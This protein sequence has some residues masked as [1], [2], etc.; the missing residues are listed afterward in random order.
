ML[1]KSRIDTLG[2]SVLLFNSALF[3][4]NQVLIKLV[5]AGLQPVLQAGLRSLLGIVPLLVF[6]WLARRRL[7]ISDGSLLPGLLCG[8]LFSAEFLFLFLALDHTSVARVSVIFYAMPVWLTVAAHFLVPGERLSLPRVIGL[9]VAVCGVALAMSVRD[10]QAGA[11]SWLGD[12]FC[13]LAS[14]CW[15]AIA[16][17]ARLTGLSRASPEMQLLYQLGVSSLVLL[18]ASLFF[19]DLVREMTPA[20]AGILVFQA[21]VVVMM[22]FLLWFWVLSIY[23]ASDMA[24]FGFLVP[25]FGVFFGWLVLDERI[26][27][28]VI[29]SLLLVSAGIVLINRKPRGA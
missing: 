23:P 29:G 17:S 28:T 14:I 11:T 4:L 26:T 13:V 15:A 8:L 10:D 20:L 24:V 9:I 21:V 5:N 1:R 16:L 25:V 22:G 18:P 27:A 2:A 6:V 12:L 3:G 7:S 19:G